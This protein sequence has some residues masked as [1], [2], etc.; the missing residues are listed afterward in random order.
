VGRASRRMV[1]LGE[2]GG[3]RFTRCRKPCRERQPHSAVANA[4]LS[5]SR[6][7]LSK[8]AHTAVIE[9]KTL[10]ACPFCK[11]PSRPLLSWVSILFR[12]HLRLFRLWR[13]I[14]GGGPCALSSRSRC[15][16]VD[17]PRIS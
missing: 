5:N 15:N 11:V 12:P 1:S 16:P 4:E 6:G 3:R 2:R 13:L 14:V 9:E 10:Y 17:Q 7:P 8:W